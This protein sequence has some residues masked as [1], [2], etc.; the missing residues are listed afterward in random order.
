MGALVV[1][2]V[3]I[4]CGVPMRPSGS[5]V[6]RLIG[7]VLILLLCLQ[8]GAVEPVQ[9]QRLKNKQ[10]ALINFNFSLHPDVRAK[11]VSFEGLYPSLPRKQR[12]G[13][14]V[15]GRLKAVCYELVRYRLQK[16]FGVMVLPL[17]TYGKRFKYDVY[18]FPEMNIE[19]A[20]RRGDA[21][22]YFS[23][24]MM[25][26]TSPESISTLSPNAYRDSILRPKDYLRPNI[27]IT[28][29]L[30]PRLGVIPEE[31]FSSTTQWPTPILLQPTM[32]DG[33]VNSQFRYDRM[34]LR[35]AIELGIDGLVE[36]I[37]KK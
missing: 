23:L 2:A 15:Q 37:R 30:Y 28:F 12:K 31:R 24:D 9:A 16:E 21:K 4:K 26:D 6:A 20:Q 11:M 7:Q 29:T 17:N 1:S 33:I 13:D 3:L 34:T 22:F 36:E 18:E 8:L 32:L 25:I 27:K 5:G 10:M 35:E 14:P 19:V